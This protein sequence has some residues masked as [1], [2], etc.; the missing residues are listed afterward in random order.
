MYSGSTATAKGCGIFN[1][2]PT[3]DKT[4][5]ERAV[6]IR[7]ADPERG[8][9]WKEDDEVYQRKIIHMFLLQ[10]KTSRSILTPRSTSTTET[11]INEPVTCLE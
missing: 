11:N 6:V 10:I 1:A 5:A 3:K 7:A 2:M 8:P 9:S 4:K